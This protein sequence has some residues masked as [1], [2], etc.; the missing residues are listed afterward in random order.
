MGAKNVLFIAVDDLRPELGAYGMDYAKTPNLDEFAKGALLFQR[1]Y[2]QYSF[3]A[4]S[5]NR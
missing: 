2:C 3:C 1:A 5:R 4:P